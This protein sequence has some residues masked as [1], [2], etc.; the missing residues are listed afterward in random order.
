MNEIRRD[1]VKTEIRPKY[2]LHRWDIFG[3]NL[4]DY[5]DVPCSIEQRPDALFLTD[6]TTRHHCSA[7]VGSLALKDRVDT[8]EEM[9][10]PADG[11]IPFTRTRVG[12]SDGFYNLDEWHCFDAAFFP[13]VTPL[14]W[15]ALL[16]EEDDLEQML[17]CHGLAFYVAPY[18]DT[19]EEMQRLLATP[20]RGESQWLQDVTN[21]YGLVLMVGHDGQYFH[22][23]A[24][25]KENLRLIEPSLTAVISAIEASQWFQAHK[26]ELAWGDDF[27]ACLMLPKQKESCTT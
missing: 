23:Y 12:F 15:Q 2:G 21:L 8:P 18:L 13:R 27:D 6:L 10:G 26:Q 19:M 11:S 1:I 25:N 24:R 20:F 7:H 5:N 16:R 14:F 9:F 17:A 4:F 22:A 3:L